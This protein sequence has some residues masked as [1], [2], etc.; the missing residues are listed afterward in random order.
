MRDMITHSHW[1]YLYCRNIKL[2]ADVASRVKHPTWSGL[3]C[4]M[5]EDL[6]E[7]IKYSEKWKLVYESL[8]PYAR[9]CPLYMTNDSSS[10]KYGSRSV[11]V[12]CDSGS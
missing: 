6:P 7:L 2:D 9:W 11:S 5:L 4:L 1:A 3:L 10:S 8:L 12:Y